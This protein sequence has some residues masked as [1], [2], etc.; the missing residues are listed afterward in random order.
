MEDWRIRG[1]NDKG[2]AIVRGVTR[3]WSFAL[4]DAG[5]ELRVANVGAPALCEVA[6]LTVHE[7]R[8]VNDAFRERARAELVVVDAQKGPTYD[9]ARHLYEGEV[10]VGEAVAALLDS[11]TQEGYYPD[12]VVLESMNID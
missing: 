12:W 10:K 1:V 11:L 5:F 9:I 2:V 3:Q 6:I 4:R 8:R 7:A